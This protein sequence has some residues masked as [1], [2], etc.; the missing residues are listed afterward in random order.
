MHDVAIAVQHHPVPGAQ[1][2][3]HGGQG[4][5]ERAFSVKQHQWLLARGAVY[6]GAGL[7]HDPGPGLGVEVSQIAE[8]ARGQE[9]G[10]EVFDP[11]LDDPFLLRVMGRTGVDLEAVTLGTFGVGALHQRVMTARLDD[12]AFGV[13]DDHA[14]RNGAE[15]FEGAPVAA[16][17]G[18]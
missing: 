6:P 9:V 15:P 12:G 4:L 16:Q 7:R 13:V 2:W 5:Q 14:S 18:G 17:P 3:R 10:F 1:V 11:R 8:R